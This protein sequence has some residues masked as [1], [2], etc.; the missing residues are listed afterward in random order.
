MAGVRIPKTGMSTMLG[1]MMVGLAAVAIVSAGT[2]MIASAQQ[3]PGQQ[4]KI[5]VTIPK[6]VCE[7]V[8]VDTQNWGQQ[9]VQMCGPPGARGQAT[10]K[11]R[12][13]THGGPKP[14]SGMPH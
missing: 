8:T 6:E 1:K 4:K 2:T 5:T 9:S 14:T 10:I 12:Q 3:K 11:R 13:M 7:T